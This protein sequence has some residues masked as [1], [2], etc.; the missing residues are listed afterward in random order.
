M[1]QKMVCGLMLVCSLVLCTASSAF[2]Q[3]AYVTSFNEP[4]TIASAPDSTTIL[5]LHNVPPGNY[6]I[7]AK[8]NVAASVGLLTLIGLYAVGYQRRRK[9]SI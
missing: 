1:R 9:S 2:G 6:V 7:N 3:T 4:M 8:L 5:S